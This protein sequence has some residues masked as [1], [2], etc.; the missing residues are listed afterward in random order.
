VSFDGNDDEESN[1]AEDIFAST[2]PFESTTAGTTGVN[3]IIGNN[4]ISN[5]QLMF[6]YQNGAYEQPSDFLINFYASQC[7]NYPF[8]ATATNIPSPYNPFHH[9]YLTHDGDVNSNNDNWAN[10]NS[11]PDNF[12]DFDS[13]F[14]SMTPIGVESSTST[15]IPH[16]QQDDTS[17]TLSSIENT[18]QESQHCFI[19]T[20]QLI[21]ISTAPPIREFQL[22]LNQSNEILPKSA[23]EEF[24]DEEFYSLRDDSNDMSSLTDDIERKFNENTE[25][26][27]DDDD[28][29]ASAD[30]R[31]NDFDSFIILNN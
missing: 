3:A 29:F 15:I 2:D 24:D 10:F 28:D 21:E 27:D 18:L 17:E 14:A 6:G 16:D 31:F 13:H 30:E 11:S 9:H 25:V 5:S 4:N 19:A 7:T 1:D 22:G 12:A 26:P 20:T 23:P 8:T